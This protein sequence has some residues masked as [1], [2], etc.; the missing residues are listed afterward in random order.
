VV[1]W[2]AKPVRLGGDWSREGDRIGET[3]W[4]GLG[5]SFGLGFNHQTAVTSLDRDQP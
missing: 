1:A 3:L 4:G 5:G 2:G